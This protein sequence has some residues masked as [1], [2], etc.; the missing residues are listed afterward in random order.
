MTNNL[1]G[2]KRDRINYFFKMG[3]DHVNKVGDP[4]P[5]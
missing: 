1:T 2:P 4:Q 5:H 3:G